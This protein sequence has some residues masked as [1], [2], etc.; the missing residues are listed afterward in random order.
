MIYWPQGQWGGVRARY[1]APVHSYAVKWSRNTKWKM[2]VDRLFTSRHQASFKMGLI[3]SPC[4]WSW[5]KVFAVNFLMPCM[6]PGHAPQGPFYSYGVH[7]R[8]VNRARNDVLHRNK[9]KLFS[10]CPA[11]YTRNSPRGPLQSTPHPG[12]KWLTCSC[13]CT[14]IVKGLTNWT[15]HQWQF[16]SIRSPFSLASS[17]CVPPLSCCCRFL[18]KLSALRT[19]TT[20]GAGYGL[21]TTSNPVGSI[22]FV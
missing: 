1:C 18:L 9:A 20:T 3:A 19:F 12:P 6:L 7:R 8:L 10:I 4:S 2:T 5:F 14:G 13:G 21:L 22:M 15:V 16:S 17:R 11:P